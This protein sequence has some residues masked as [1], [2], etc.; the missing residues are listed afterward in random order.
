MAYEQNKTSSCDIMRPR[1][2]LLSWHGSTGCQATSV[3]GAM[4]FQIILRTRLKRTAQL[5]EFLVR[6]FVQASEMLGQKAA[7]VNVYLQFSRDCSQKR[8]IAHDFFAAIIRKL[9]TTVT[10][11]LL[12]L[13]V[14]AIGSVVAWAN[15]K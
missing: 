9:V 4:F 12:L 5:C 10:D 8:F 7:F 6:F 2:E 15:L 11:S 3:R 14:V 13:G 1:P